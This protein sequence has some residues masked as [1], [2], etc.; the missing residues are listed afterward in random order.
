MHCSGTVYTAPGSSH[1]ALGL[2]ILLLQGLHT[3]LQGLCMALRLCTLLWGLCRLLL[4]LCTLLW[5]SAHC[6]GGSAHCSRAL[7]TTPGLLCIALALCTLLQGLCVLLRG[8][9]TLLWGSLRCFAVI[10]R[11]SLT[12]C[13]CSCSCCPLLSSRPLPGSRRGCITATSQAP[14]ASPRRP[15]T[16]CV[17]GHTSI[18]QG[19]AS[20]APMAF[21][22]CGACPAPRGPWSPGCGTFGA[23]TALPH[24]QPGPGSSFPAH[25]GE[26][27]SPHPR[28]GQSPAVHRS[29]RGGF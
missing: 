2:C 8:P 23:G 1:I 10:L 9:W 24:Q 7:Y 27:G 11:L 26:V 15:L 17:S 13:S 25:P 20:P 29:S 14:S 21:C 18:S 28:R 12:K 6:S 22:S 19:S 5:G 16:A 4:G 3:Q